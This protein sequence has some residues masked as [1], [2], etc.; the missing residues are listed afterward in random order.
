MS[1]QVQDRRDEQVLELREQRRS[2]AAI[3]KAVGFERASEA[4]VAFN[5]ALRRRSSKEQEVL[6]KAE[7]GRLDEMARRVRENNEL[8]PDDTERRLE[9]VDRLRARL[10]A[11]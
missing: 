7:L 6:R 3:A 9:A 8:T 10:L 2:F 1:D 5:R 11:P 4:S